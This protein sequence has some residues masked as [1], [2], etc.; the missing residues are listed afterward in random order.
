ML[1]RRLPLLWT[2][3]GGCLSSA[4]LIGLWPG[5]SETS[6][7]PKKRDVVVRNTEASS[8]VAPPS[9]ATSAV[10]ERAIPDETSDAR[11]EPGSSVADVLTRLEAAYRQ[12]LSAAAPV[13]AP[14]PAAEHAPAPPSG[15]TTIAEAPARDRTAVA[16]AATATP[17][18]SAPEVVAQAAVA[19]EAEPA[20]VLA[21]RDVAGPRD[22]HV[23]DVHQNTHVGNVHQGDVNVVQQVALLQ[24]FQLLTLPPQNRFSSPAQR[25]RGGNRHVAPYTFPLTNPDNPWGFDFPPTVLVK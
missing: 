14:P 10:R 5:A 19:P 16:L 22:I 2:F 24:Y 12:G 3:A 7:P 9:A 13:A 18:K 4:V 17:P 23:G 21:V 11:A 25:P 1:T 6:S 20:P 8:P 15:T